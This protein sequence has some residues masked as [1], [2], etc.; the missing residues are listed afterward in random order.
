V[1]YGSSSTKFLC[2]GLAKNSSGYSV[3]HMTILSA[4]PGLYPWIS[5]H[6][7]IA[8]KSLIAAV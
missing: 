5:V 2:G 6:I 4:N 1:K 7:C 8:E 3:L